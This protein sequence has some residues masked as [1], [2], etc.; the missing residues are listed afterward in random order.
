MLIL[1]LNFIR[2]NL[3]LTYF[4]NMRQVVLVDYA[5]DKIPMT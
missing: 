2:F 5:R 4:I 3:Y 1:F